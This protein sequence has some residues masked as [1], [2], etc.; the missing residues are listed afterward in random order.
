MNFKAVLNKN[1]WAAITVYAA[2]GECLGENMP[3]Y[4][5]STTKTAEVLKFFQNLRRFC[6]WLPPKI[7]VAMD[8]AK[9]HQSDYLR[10][11]LDSLGFQI[12]FTPSYSPEFNSIER[13]WGT[14]K[15]TL[16]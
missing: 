8:N 9:A 15:S 4:L 16:K 11:E 13:V 7:W 10:T 12:L 14:F 6:T 2:I 1:R 3:Y 5:G